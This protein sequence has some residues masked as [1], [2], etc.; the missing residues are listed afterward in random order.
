MRQ[1]VNENMIAVSALCP[2]FDPTKHET[3]TQCC[4]NVGPASATLAKHYCDIEFAR[5]TPYSNPFQW[6]SWNVRT[7][8][9]DQCAHY[10]SSHILVKCLKL[11]AWKVADRGFEPHS[12][13]Q[14][15]K[16]QTVSSP[17]TRED[18]KY[19]AELWWPKGSVLGRR[20]TGL[21]FP[22]LCT[23][24]VSSHSFHHPQEVL[25]VQ[26]SL[27][28]HNGGLKPHSFSFVLSQRS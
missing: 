8:E 16:K 3:R 28:M 21:E 12:G 26:F 25:L 27:Y 15:S 22:I 17:L 14:V 4:C 6:N 19:C 23:R 1:F 5:R 13:L 24:A 10:I 18:L 2:T 7:V 20:P 11:P 9:V